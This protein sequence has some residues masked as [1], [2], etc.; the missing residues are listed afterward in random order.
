MNNP[1]NEKFGRLLVL[2]ET[3]KKHIFECL[4]NC[5]NTKYVQ[6]SNLL[7]GNTKSCGCLVKELTSKRFR[8][9]NFRW[10]SFYIIWRNMKQRCNDIK[11]KYYNYYGGRGITYDPRWNNFLEFKK[12][13][14]QSYI[15]S[16]KKYRQ[17]LKKKNNPLTIER[18]DVNGNYTKENCCF[19]PMSRQGKNR[20]MFVTQK[21]FEAIS[22]KGIREVSNNQSDFARKYNLS[23]G[24]VGACLRKERRQHKKWHFRYLTEEEIKQLEVKRI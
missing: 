6:K 3:N 1:I 8:K 12:D 10:T 22:P 7:S 23:Q 14:Y 18:K 13:M 4:C 9:H 2:K 20:R 17:E 11:H 21:W 16:K 5:G 15:F 19:I 24:N